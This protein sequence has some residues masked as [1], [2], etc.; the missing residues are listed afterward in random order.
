MDLQGV[1]GCGII[2]EKGVFCVKITADFNK[3]TGKIKPMHGV[4]QPPYYESGK[5]MHY[6]AEAGIPYSRLHDVGGPY[7]GGKFVDIHNIFRDFDADE[8]LP[9]SYDF[10]F[11]DELI[12]SLIENNVMPFFRLGET[13]ENNYETKAYYIYPPKD[14]EKWARICEHI[15]RH[16][17]EGWANGFHYGIEYWEIWNEP[18][19]HKHGQ[20]GPMWIG[21]KEEYFRLYEVTSNHLKK[22]FGDTIKIGGYSTCDFSMK[23]AFYEDTQCAGLK[24]PYDNNAQYHVQYM[25]DFFKYIT[26]EEHKSPIDYFSWH[27]YSGVGIALDA[28]DYLRRVMEKYGFGDLEACLTEWNTDFDVKTNHTPYAAAKA[29][30]MMLGMQK[31]RVDMLCYYDA[32]MANSQYG[33]LF[34]GLERKPFLTYFAFMMF[35]DAYK[36]ENEVETAS[37]NKDIFVMGAKK[38]NRAVLII[39]NVGDKTEA[40]LDLSGVDLNGAEVLIIDDVYH[41]SPTGIDISDGK[42]TIPEKSCVEIRFY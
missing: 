39:S 40:N 23:N 13:I 29:L 4:G 24:G 12:T 5:H 19:G 3:I 33:G 17:N 34:N 26:S 25:H 32:R 11:T 22:C 21:T 35:N 28:A 38:D 20:H 14:F 31:K 18:E 36:L 15:I 41:Y 1:N 16:Y 9:E 30:A 42:L 7:G 2:K 10:A 8:T 27:T 37:D 6:L